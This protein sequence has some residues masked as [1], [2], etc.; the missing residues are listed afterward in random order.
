MSESLSLV[1][2]PSTLPNPD[3]CEERIAVVTVILIAA[4]MKRM[5]RD[6]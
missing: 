6:S 5:R 1:E 3:I 2:T 4:L